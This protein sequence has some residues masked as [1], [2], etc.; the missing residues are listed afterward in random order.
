MQSSMP[1]TIKMK[2]S[3]WTSSIID[4]RVETDDTRCHVERGVEE[5]RRD[6]L[7]GQPTQAFHMLGQR[8]LRA[9]A[10]IHVHV[11]VRSPSRSAARV[12]FLAICRI[13]TTRPCSS[14]QRLTRRRRTDGKQQQDHEKTCAFCSRVQISALR[15]Q[16]HYSSAEGG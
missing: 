9:L 12:H 16:R 3:L 2:L 7:N 4:D 10:A 14:T 8:R 6:H 15:E 5:D 11:H 13:S 1:I